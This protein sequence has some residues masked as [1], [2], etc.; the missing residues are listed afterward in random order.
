M[1]FVTD[2]RG[3]ARQKPYIAT[4]KVYS[5]YSAELSLDVWIELRADVAP[6]DCSVLRKVLDQ[7]WTSIGFVG[8]A[9]EITP[10]KHR[11]HMFPVDWAEDGLSF[12]P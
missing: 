9:V 2:K 8:S 12:S 7:G 5:E 6:T 3:E 11:N 1:T 4:I 10:P